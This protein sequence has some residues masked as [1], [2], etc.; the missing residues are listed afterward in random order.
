LWDTL[1]G[2]AR[3]AAVV[4]TVKSG[5]ATTTSRFFGLQADAAYA[6]GRQRADDEAAEQSGGGVV[7]VAVEVADEVE[8]VWGGHRASEEVVGGDS[9]PDEGGG[10]APKAAGRW[11]PVLLHQVKVDVGFVYQLGDEAGGAVRGV[12]G[13]FGD[14]VRP[15]AVNLHQR[16]RR[17]VQAY[18]HGEREREPYGV[19]ARAEVSPRSPVPEPRS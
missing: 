9:A 2:R 15:D 11:D 10:A 16:V 8:E 13:V 5:T 1:S 14:H 4:E 7:R 18:P 17:P 19:V 3:L 12:V 6:L